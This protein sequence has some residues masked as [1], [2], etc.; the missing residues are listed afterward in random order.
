MTRHRRS[1]GREGEERAARHLE[2]RGY[3]IVARNVRVARVEID[4]G[5]HPLRAADVVPELALL[6]V[7]VRIAHRASRLGSSRQRRK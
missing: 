3:Q 6:F 1:L 5:V 4:L 2:A 7:R